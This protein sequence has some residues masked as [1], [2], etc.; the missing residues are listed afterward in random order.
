MNQSKTD[1]ELIFVPLG[2]VGEFGKN[3]ALYGYAGQWIIVDCGMAFADETMPGIDLLVPDVS[4]IAEQ[5]DRLLGLVLTHGHEDHLGGVPF[6]WPRLECPV[7]ATPYT[8]SQLGRKL[9]EAGLSDQ[10]PV[11][12][13]PPG[14]SVTLG[15]F[16][17][18]YVQVAHSILEAHSLAIRTPAGLIV[19]SGDWKI[20]PEPLI[21]PL[22]D[23]AQFRELGDEGVLALIGDS[24]NVFVPGHSG[25]EGA[26]RRS[27]TE[28]IAKKTGKVAVTTFASN[29]PR[30]QSIVYAARDNGREVVV[31]GRSLWRTIELAKENGYLSDL[32][33]LLND[34]EAEYLPAENTLFLVTGCQ[35]ET[36]GAMSRIASG[37]H[38][39]IVFGPGDTVIFSSKIIPG[40]E[41]S[42]GAAV[43]R[44]IYS[45]VEVITEKDEF[46]HVSGHPGQEEMVQMYDWLRPTVAVPVHGDARNLSRHAALAIAAGV[47]QTL[48]I[49]NGSV[50]RLAPGPA[51]VVDH[52]QTGRLAIMGSKPVPIDSDSLRARR[53]LGFNGMILA[54][55]VLDGDGAVAAPVRVML[56]GVG[57]DDGEA[58]GDAER[59]L[60][61]GLDAMSRAR[62]REDD[63]VESMAR[64]ALRGE[65]RRL[66][67]Q[68]PGI[69]VEIIRLAETEAVSYR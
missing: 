24:T 54:I 61:K 22:T 8:A 11:N 40:N 10:V 6:V 30:L 20:D 32:P 29:A 25:S 4:F 47:D 31:V 9:D 43:N 53:K 12:V 62:R 65:A 33:T 14:G 18:N 2:G 66:S 35:G 26:L 1:N 13:V 36:R 56:R 34:D 48:I 49:E 59:T 50:V 27:L 19:H 57:A 67:S 60:R 44:L 15:P 38:K 64:K 5:K 28:I 7:Y 23:E 63:K 16:E 69:E 37:Q 42:V 3:L 17:I 58:Q 52:V 68:R 21:G 45:G 55:I 51:A 46:V 41:I 39:R